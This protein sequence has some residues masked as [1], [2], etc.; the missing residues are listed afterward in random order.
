ME[1]LKQ[2]IMPLNELVASLIKFAT[3]AI[4]TYLHDHE[5]KLEITELQE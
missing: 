2:F 4:H 5:D 1:P 3:T